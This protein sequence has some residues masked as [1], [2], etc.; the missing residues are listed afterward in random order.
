MKIYEYIEKKDT[1]SGFGDG[2]TELGKLNSNVVALCADLTG[3]L[4]MNEF[5]KNHPERF[6]QIGI[7]EA[8]MMGIAAG[9]TI[10]GKIPFTGTFANFSTGRVYDQIRQ[11]I[12]YSGKNVKIC[13]SHAG[14]T[15][16]EDGA[17]HQILEDIGMMKMLP[18]M[19][20]INTCDYNQ[21]KAATISIA[22]HKGPVY[23]RFGRPKVPVFMPENQK[24]EIGKAVKLQE[25][26][27]VTIIATGHLV[28]EALEAYKVLYENG[29]TADIINIHTIK[30]LDKESIIT[31]I[32]KTG[33]VVTA[34]E[35]NYYGGLGESVSRLLSSNTPKPQEFVAVNDTFGESGT[36]AQLMEKYGLSANVIVEKVKKV[37]KR[38]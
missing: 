33:C 22:N 5:K 19:T 30:P 2:L 15:L 37:I 4:K 23:L 26:N 25:G 38:K 16:G 8:N 31:S 35:H 27:D 3:S 24:F 10:G 29:I 7:A 36:P 12:A 32:E 14:I 6:F 13:A 9:L 17:T 1:R 18:G 20:V 21:T 34:E 28:W 11:S